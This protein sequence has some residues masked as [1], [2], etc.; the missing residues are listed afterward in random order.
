MT[1][2]TLTPQ[3]HRAA[4]LYASGLQRQEIARRMG[5]L[6]STVDQHV[7][8]AKHKLDVT[9]RRELA[10]ALASCR[11]Q[12]RV[13]GGMQP[14]RR[15]EQ[16]RIVGG[17]YVGRAATFLKASNATA[18]AVQIGAGRVAVTRRFVA[19]AEHA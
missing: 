15:G 8:E 13:K 6:A 12:M 1:V 14:F 2:V 4:T 11:A 9:T 7:R 16:V 3:Q 19:P 18:Y 10:V 5:I 17:R